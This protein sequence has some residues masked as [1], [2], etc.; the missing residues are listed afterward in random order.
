MDEPTV[1][2]RR[3]DGR[4]A[5][6]LRKV[7]IEAPYLRHAEGSVSI[8]M[9]NTWVICSAT[10]EDRQ[11]AFLKGTSKGWVTAEYGMLPRSVQERVGRARLPGRGTEI[12]RIIGRSLRSVIDLVG[13]PEHTIKID[14]DVIEADGG[15]RAAAVTGAFVALCQACRWMVWQGR[16]P[17]IPIRD[18]VAAIG[19][20]LV[21]GQVLCDLTYEEDSAADVDLNVFMTGQGS[22]VGLQGAAEQAPFNDAELRSMLTVARAGLRRLFATQR[23]ALGLGPADAFD[24]GR[25]WPTTP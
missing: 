2:N 18:Q 5:K 12:Q 21:G 11:P 15:T 3:G 17:R 4:G 16:I 9:G 1:D 24:P 10:V 23:R 25:I 19:V 6:D 22:Y 20:G 13:I 8:R 14:C 7:T